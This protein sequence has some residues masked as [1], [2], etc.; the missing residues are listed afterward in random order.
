MSYTVDELLAT[1]RR[2]IEDTVSPYLWSDAEFL[3]YL[4]EAQ[5][6]FAAH[7]R[8]LTRQITL[9]YTASDTFLVV[10]DYVVDIRRINAPSGQ[11]VSLY[12][13]ETWYEARTT[14]DYGRRIFN[15][16]WE[17]DSSEEPEAVITD[18]VTDQIRL[19]P[20]P[21]VDGSLSLNIYSTPF[22]TPIDGDELEITKKPYQLCILLK[23]YALAY[24]KHDSETF[25][26]ELAGQFENNY[27]EKRMELQHRID[28][29]RRRPQAVRYGGL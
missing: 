19:Y 25:N 20:I 23:V 16:Q 27:T 8:V 15:T 29:R 6:D 24:K 22:T 10:P 14:T 1:F 21:T 17:T 7:T 9:P 12:N 28:Q 18:I 26:P 3:Q 11:K 5:D 2:E 13:E 4:D